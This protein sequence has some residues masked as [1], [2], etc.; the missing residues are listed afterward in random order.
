MNI[1]NFNSL[2]CSTDIYNLL[3]FGNNILAIIIIIIMWDRGVALVK[4]LCF[5]SEG[6]WFDYRCFH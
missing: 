5:K 6:R 1:G 4:V 2:H 3:I